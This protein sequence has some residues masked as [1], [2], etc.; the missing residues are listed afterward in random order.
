MFEHFLS[1]ALVL[2]IAGEAVLL[3]VAISLILV[4]ASAVLKETSE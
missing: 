3:V 1:V 2:V 4:A